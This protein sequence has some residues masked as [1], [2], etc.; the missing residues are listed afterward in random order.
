[1]IFEDNVDTSIDDVGISVAL[2]A[3]AGE[4]TADVLVIDG[5][6]KIND[7]SNI[8]VKHPKSEDLIIHFFFLCC[9][10]VL[11]FNNQFR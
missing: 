5:F 2:V 3:F 1:M 7:K 6:I 4:V 8:K 11:A 10:V 9:C